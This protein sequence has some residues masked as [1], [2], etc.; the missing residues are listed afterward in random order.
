MGLTEY[1]KNPTKCPFCQSDNIEGEEIETGGGEASQQ[2]GCNDCGEEWVDGYRLVTVTQESEI[3]ILTPRIIVVVEGGVVRKII[4]DTTVE[5]VIC[6]QDVNG[7][8]EE[9]IAT[10][11]EGE[12]AFYSVMAPEIDSEL[13]DRHYTAGNPPIND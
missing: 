13:V 10:T 11:P 2:M 1:L 7:L 8:D 3:E 9:Q 12:E 6:D 5:I 4:S